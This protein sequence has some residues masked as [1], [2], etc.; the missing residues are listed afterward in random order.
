[1]CGRSSHPRDHWLPPRDVDMTQARKEHSPYHVYRPWPDLGVTSHDGHAGSKRPVNAEHH[2]L[3]APGQHREGAHCKGLVTPERHLPVVSHA[4]KRGQRSAR[5]KGEPAAGF[6]ACKARG[7]GN[8]GV[9]AGG[10]GQQGGRVRYR[11]AA[12]PS[13]PLC[14]DRLGPGKAPRRLHIGPAWRLT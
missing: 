13:S 6:R 2:T 5:A 12:Q 11:G 4:P 14:T 10:R 9:R 7:S 1:M 3:H 8:I